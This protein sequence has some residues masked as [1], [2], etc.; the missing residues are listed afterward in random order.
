[1]KWQRA[2]IMKNWKRTRIFGT[3]WEKPF[4]SIVTPELHTLNVGAG[5]QR[6]QG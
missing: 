5:T 6:Y 3:A 1:M 4:C 2:L